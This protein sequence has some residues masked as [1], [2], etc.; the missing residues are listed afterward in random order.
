[1]TFLVIAERGGADACLK[2]V[3]VETIYQAREVF[4]HRVAMAIQHGEW[5]RV[6][7]VALP[8][9]RSPMPSPI[10]AFDVTGVDVQVIDREDDKYRWFDRETETTWTRP[11][12]WAYAMVCKDR[13]RW[14]K[15]AQDTGPN[16]NLAVAVE[17]GYK[18]CEKGHNLQM[19]LLNAQKTFA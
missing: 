4:D 15:N 19:A 13:D 3:E 1:M 2:S 11:T 12:A 10:M 18:E 5:S 9:E 7:V 8:T 16:S 17:F 14:Q 6:Q